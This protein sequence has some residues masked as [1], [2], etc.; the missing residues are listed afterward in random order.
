MPQSTEWSLPIPEGPQFE[1]SHQR[2][3]KENVFT[4]NCI[5]KTKIKKKRS[6]MAHVLSDVIASN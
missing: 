5:E 2:F 4:V 1:S 3:F 6:E